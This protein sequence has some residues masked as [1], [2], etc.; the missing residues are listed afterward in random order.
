LCAAQL[1]YV[2]GLEAAGARNLT[3]RN[4]PNSGEFLPLENPAEF[5]C[6]VRDF[7]QRV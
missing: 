3:H 1:A 2:R 7:V 6:V 5:V 4:I